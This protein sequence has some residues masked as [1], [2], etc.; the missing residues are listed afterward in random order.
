VFRFTFLFAFL[1]AFLFT[2]LFALR[3]LLTLRLRLAFAKAVRAS[4]RAE[5]AMA[6]GSGSAD[7]ADCPPTG[8]SDIRRRVD[9]PSNNRVMILSFFDSGFGHVWRAGEL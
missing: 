7:M 5:P 6:A 2:F 8:A 4:W 3:L 9:I 1:F